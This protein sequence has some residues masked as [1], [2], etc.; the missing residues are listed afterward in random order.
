MPSWEINSTSIVDSGGAGGDAPPTDQS[1]RRAYAIY[2]D[3]HGRPWGASIENKTGDPCGPMEPQFRAP[4]RPNDKYL[5]VNSRMRQIVI[6]YADMILDIEE[7]NAEWDRE[8]RDFARMNY[9]D[10][11]HEAILNPPPA[12]LDLVG[13]K[14]NGIG[15]R[16]PW[17]AAMQGNKW[18]LGLADAKPQWAEEF[19]PEVEVK[20]ETRVLEITATYPDAEEEGVEAAESVSPEYPSWSGP[21]KGWKLSD[22]TFVDRDESE[23]K[24]PFKAR[25]LA[26]QA[27]LEA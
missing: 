15:A 20:R 18:I 4:L 12:L 14:P 1:R 25:A 23:E 11:A 5:T 24:E 8:L 21:Q 9:G 26:A 7:A 16:E 6:R 2:T 17:E 10:K 13:P 19:F 3:Q 22:G 27:A